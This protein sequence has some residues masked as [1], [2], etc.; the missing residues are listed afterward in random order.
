MAPVQ[1]PDARQDFVKSPVPNGLAREHAKARDHFLLYSHFLIYPFSYV[2]LDR[3]YNT[4][5]R[6]PMRAKPCQRLSGATR[7]EA[8][9]KTTDVDE[10]GL[11]NME[12]S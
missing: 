10:R 11:P 7:R 9:W 1:R 12:T 3:A 4:K 2:Y 5:M 6:V 8:K